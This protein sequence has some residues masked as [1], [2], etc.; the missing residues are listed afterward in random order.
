M[1]WPGRTRPRCPQPMMASVT[2]CEGKESARSWGMVFALE[3]EDPGSLRERRHALLAALARGIADRTGLIARMSG[4]SGACH[5]VGPRPTWT[6]QD[7]DSIAADAREW[8]GVGDIDFGRTVGTRSVQRVPDR[9]GRPTRANGLPG[10]VYQCTILLGLRSAW[11]T[12]TLPLWRHIPIH[13]QSL[14][15]YGALGRPT[16]PDL[17]PVVVGRS[18][19][20]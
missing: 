17:V 11:S 2:G 9:C 16:R 15:A 6:G 19:R 7:S 14:W 10:I 8:L 20:E 3:R 4:R 1:N 12:C 13:K 18:E 5:A